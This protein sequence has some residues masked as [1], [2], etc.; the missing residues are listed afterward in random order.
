M[1]KEEL[2]H[3]NQEHHMF[4]RGDHIVV[5]VSGGADSVCLLELLYELREKWDLMLYVLHVHHGIRGEEADRDACF[6]EGLARDWQLPFYLVRVNVPEEA[7]RRGMSEEETG[8][9][10]RYEALEEYRRRI[11]GDRIALAHH[12]GDQAETVLFRM[13][14]GSGPRGLAGIP[15]RRGTIIRPLL[16]AGRQE[17]E[18]ELRQKGISWCQD[19]TNG[20]LKYTRNRIRH[21]ILALAEEH[22]NAQAAKHI[23]QAAEKIA[24]WRDYIEK[25][26][27]QAYE[28]I[29]LHEKGQIMIGAAEFAREDAVIQDEILRRVFEIMIPGARDVGRI[30]YEQVIKLLDAPAGKRQNLPMG[31]CAE[32]QYDKIC[33]R[34][35]TEKKEETVRI[36]CEMPSVHIVERDGILWRF[37]LE[38]KKRG[39]LPE[40]IPQKDYTKWFNYDMI[41]DGLVIRSPKEGDYFVLDDTGRT[42]RLNRYYIDKKIPR[43]K[44]SSQL[45]VA[46]GDHILWAVPDRISEAYKIT[47][48][49]ERVLVITKERILS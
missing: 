37:S 2:E 44:R 47:K 11:G 32:R 17:I 4:D 22:I 10:L 30:H 18:E 42:K 48:N 31:I 33:V 13:F 7:V 14:R 43:S 35:G 36:V 21:E 23:V 49:T 9:C 5:G 8:R 27:D 12:Q 34:K 6:V 39:D 45:V 25:C 29:V 24:A 28:R 16:F 20:Q 1:L 26:G 41:K 38:V 40:E 15:L 19:T 46:E 3:F